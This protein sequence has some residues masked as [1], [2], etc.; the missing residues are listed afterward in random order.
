MQ[1]GLLSRRKVYFSDRQ[2]GFSCQLFYSSDA[3]DE[4]CYFHSAMGHPSD[5]FLTA[6]NSFDRSL[7]K[8]GSD[9]SPPRSLM[10][11]Q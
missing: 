11:K 6:I 2:V 4:E 5:S 10:V 7:E 9:S 8:V 1:E 3:Y